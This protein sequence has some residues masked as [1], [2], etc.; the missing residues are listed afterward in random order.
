M[1]VKEDWDIVVQHCPDSTRH[2][3]SMSWDYSHD[4]FIPSSQDFIP[5]QPRKCVYVTGGR[6]GGVLWIQMLFLQYKL[7]CNTSTEFCIVNVSLRPVCLLVLVTK[8]IDYVLRVISVMTSL[9]L[10]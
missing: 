5:P 6:G 1:K 8:C 7:Q 3:L 4:D 2:S 10:V 9:T